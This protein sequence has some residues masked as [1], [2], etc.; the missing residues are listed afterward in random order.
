MWGLLKPD[1]SHKLRPEKVIYRDL[2]LND[3]AIIVLFHAKCRDE[4]Q[5]SIVYFGHKYMQIFRIF[6]M[7]CDKNRKVYHNW[8]EIEV[9]I[10]K[11]EPLSAK[12]TPKIC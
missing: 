7:I 11:N 6:Q 4:E 10:D 3:A 9:E 2:G 5:Q 1:A 12:L 8:H